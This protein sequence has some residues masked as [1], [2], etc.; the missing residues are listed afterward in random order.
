M[1]EFIEK[2]VDQ[3]V[4]KELG[5]EQD[6]YT[7]NKLMG[8]LKKVFA[9]TNLDKPTQDWICFLL[10]KYIKANAGVEEAKVV[11][12]KSK[13]LTYYSL[14]TNVVIAVAALV[15]FFIHG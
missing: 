7:Q 15:W 13:K 6:D 4:V 1:A 8:D 2:Y 3:D 12:E 9:E 10:G 14:I 5:I 11:G